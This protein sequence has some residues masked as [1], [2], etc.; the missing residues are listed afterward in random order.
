MWK[1]F[2]VLTFLL[3]LVTGY[4]W[5]SFIIAPRIYLFAIDVLMIVTLLMSKVRLKS[6]PHV[7]LM[8]I[9]VIVMFF[10]SLW[11]RDMITA[12]V[13]LLKFSPAILLFMLDKSH[14][15][16]LLDSV[17]KWLGIILSVS[18]LIFITTLFVPIP[19]L[20]KFWPESLHTVYHPYENYFFFIREQYNHFAYRFNGPFLEPGHLSLICMMLLFANRLD[21]KRQP[22]LWM[23]LASV[24]VSL[25]LAGYILLGVAIVLLRL[26][27]FASA[28][29]IT[30]IVGLAYI[31][32]TQLWNNGNNIVNEMVFAR[33]EYDKTRG[34]KGNNRTVVATDKFFNQC[35]ADGT[36]WLGVKNTSNKGDKIMG[37]GYKIFLLNRGVVMLFIVT[38]FYLLLIPKYSNR[39]YAASF[40]LFIGLCFMQRGYPEWFSWLFSFAIGVGITRHEKIFSA[41][42]KKLKKKNERLT[43]RNTRQSAV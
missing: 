11:R 1:T 30:I 39:R 18:M 43:I 23:L 25:S 27:N 2:K 35:V 38:A 21:F 36:I 32:V 22:W 26:R 42:P 17:T 34:I 3:I 6:S 16:N 14:Q 19:S 12:Q 10:Y 40:L 37:A 41:K 15:R 28:V 13:N 24:L 4:V 20:G 8:I 31:G 7:P 33:L 9:T 29:I 5:F